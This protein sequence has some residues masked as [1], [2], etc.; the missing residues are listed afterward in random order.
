MPNLSEVI[1]R[2]VEMELNDDTKPDNEA[3]FAVP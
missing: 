2:Q 3:A 1:R